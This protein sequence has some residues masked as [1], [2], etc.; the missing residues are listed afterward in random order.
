MVIGE[1]KRLFDETLCILNNTEP[2]TAN[3]IRKQK[4]HWYRDNREWGK[5]QHRIKNDAL[6][7][8]LKLKP[9]WIMGLDADEVF[10]YTLTRKALED[11]AQ[12]GERAWYFYFINLW[13]D[14]E[15][16]LPELCFW[17]CIFFKVLNNF[18]IQVGNQPLHPGLVPEYARQ[19]GFYAPYI[20][21][22]Y[23]LMKKEDRQKKVERYEKYDPRAIYK[24]SSYY[25]SLK[26]KSP[27]IPFDESRVIKMVENEVATYKRKIPKIIMPKKTGEYVFVMRPDDNVIIDIPKEHLE[28]HLKRGFKYVG[29]AGRAREPEAQVVTTPTQSTA[30]SHTVLPRRRGRPSRAK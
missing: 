21:K 27:G 19:Y 10:G 7:Y 13:N 15:H 28:E 30:P 20:V 25:D 3:L 8:L 4:F 18:P 5:E 12:K 16:Y 17:K 23:G 2:E 29:E 11:L 9:E 22:H 6:A 14:Q 24:S 1:H 26:S